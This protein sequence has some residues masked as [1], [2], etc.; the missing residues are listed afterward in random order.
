VPVA[1]GRASLRCPAQRGEGGLVAQPVRA[2]GGP[3][4][5]TAAA[6]SGRRPSPHSVTSARNLALPIGELLDLKL[7]QDALRA[8]S[9]AQ[10]HNPPSATSPRTNCATPTRRALQVRGIAS[11]AS[12]GSREDRCGSVDLGSRRGS[13]GRSDL[14]QTRPGNC[15]D[16]RVPLCGCIGCNAEASFRL[17]AKDP[18]Q[19][20]DGLDGDEVAPLQ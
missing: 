11:D 15:V 17:K 18:A 3:R 8:D 13:R 6:A 14:R 10:K 5:S 7:P 2:P 12:L 4:S 1:R 16:V 9:P 20:G 19:L